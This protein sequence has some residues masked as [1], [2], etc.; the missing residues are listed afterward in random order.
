MEIKR[1]SS[2]NQIFL[3]CLKTIAFLICA[4]CPILFLPLTICM[5]F[6]T[7]NKMK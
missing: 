6:Q 7:E 2:S 1:N 3:N 5:E 4:T